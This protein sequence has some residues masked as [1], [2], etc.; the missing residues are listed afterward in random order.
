MKTYPN[1]VPSGISI[2]P[3]VSGLGA[4]GSSTLPFGTMYANTF[5][6]DTTILNY[7][8]DGGG[9][10][11][12]SGCQG[13]VKIP[14][15]AIPLAWDLIACSSGTISVDVRRKTYATWSGVAT[16]S[17]DSIVG[18]EKPTISGTYKNQNTSLTTWSGVSANDILQ[19]FVD[20][21]PTLI[22]Q[23]TLGI[24]LKKNS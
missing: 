20:A 6:G 8:M 7:V 16:S 21:N 18:T 2:L 13:F 19:I 23:C 4:Y 1:S 5:V 10:V 12:S 14:Y 3:E 15:N 17:A 24:K 22:M 11:I 9:S